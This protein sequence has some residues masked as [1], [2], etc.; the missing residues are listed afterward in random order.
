MSKLEKEEER[1]EM[2]RLELERRKLEAEERMLEEKENRMLE[3]E[4]H[5]ERE[6]DQNK[7]NTAPSQ[8]THSVMSALA[9]APQVVVMRE[10][11]PT[12]VVVGGGHQGSRG[13]EHDLCLAYL[14]CFFCFPL[15]RAYL[16][17][18]G[19]CLL[20]CLT[21]GCCGIGN[22]QSPLLLPNIGIDHLS[23]HR[24]SH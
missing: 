24:R 22:W 11:G 15:H 14:L 19:G 2:K 4:L 9:S 10:P 17:D 13:R 3:R 8:H 18:C 21:Q 16:G 7:R 23:T 12:T 5:R 20:C 6:R 1:I